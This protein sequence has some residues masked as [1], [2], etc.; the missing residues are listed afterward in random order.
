LPAE[1][2]SG[3]TLEER[4]ATPAGLSIERSPAESPLRFESM[5]L[6]TVAHAPVS[7]MKVPPML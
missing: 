5:L 2:V 4:P 3:D 7:A 6:R 1:F